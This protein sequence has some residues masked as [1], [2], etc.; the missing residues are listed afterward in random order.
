MKGVTLCEVNAWGSTTLAEGR[1][2]LSADTW[3]AA[4]V[5]VGATGSSGAGSTGRGAAADGTAGSGRVGGGTEDVGTGRPEGELLCVPG[6]I[7]G[8]A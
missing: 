3:A 7:E 6:R 2:T 8:E 1:T 5:G 4:E